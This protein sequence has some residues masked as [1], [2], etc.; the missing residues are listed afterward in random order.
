MSD[1]PDDERDALVA[2]GHPF[3]VLG[4]GRNAVGM[5]L[6]DDTDWD[7]VTE[8]VTESYCVLAPMKLV[9]LV[10]RPEA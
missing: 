2:T 10:E 3:F 6:D 7:E 5:V 8:I 1:S 4:W 9:A